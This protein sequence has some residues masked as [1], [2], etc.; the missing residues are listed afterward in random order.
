[1]YDYKNMAENI[2]AYFLNSQLIGVNMLETI[3][4][5]IEYL[6][7]MLSEKKKAQY[8]SLGKMITQSL[9]LESHMDKEWTERL[10]SFIKSSS[11]IVIMLFWSLCIPTIFSN[12]YL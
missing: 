10:S 3:L 6:C 4:P 5:N 9:E 12:R 11:N 2:L 7:E 8:I 1:M